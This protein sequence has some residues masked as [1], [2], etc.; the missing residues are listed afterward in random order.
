MYFQFQLFLLGVSD[1]RAWYARERCDLQAIALACRA[2]MH[3]VHEHD[4]VAVPVRAWSRWRPFL[5]V[6]KLPLSVPS[7]RVAYEGTVMG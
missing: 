5:P 2:V 4:V 7:N 6:T 3:G 1:H